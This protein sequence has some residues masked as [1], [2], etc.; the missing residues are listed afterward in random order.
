MIITVASGKGGTGKTT[1]AVSLALALRELA[2]VQFIDA[3]VEAPN[4]HLFLDPVLSESR[5]VDKL[6][7]VIDETACQL[8][9]ACSQACEFGAIAQLGDRV[10]VYPTLCHGC[11]RCRLVCGFNA[12]SETPQPLGIVQT[13]EAQGMAYAQGCLHIGQAMSTP[14]IHALRD[15]IDAS[16]VCILDAPPGT[17]CPAIAAL[18]PANAALLV[19]EPTPFGLHDLRAA[20]AVARTLDRPIAVVINREGIGDDAVERYCDKEAI[21]VLMK[22]EFSREIAAAYAVGRTL[23]SVDARWKERFLTLFE[24]LSELSS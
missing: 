1:I 10:L 21:P 2:P 4:A 24:A 8:C 18:A 11:G 6:L 23:L 7:P 13:G 22:I 15:R 20:V 17:G 9:G 5:Q 16:K 3:D 19:T 12:I 14:I